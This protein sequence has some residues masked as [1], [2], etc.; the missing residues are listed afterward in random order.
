MFLRKIVLAL[1]AFLVFSIPLAGGQLSFDVS[2]GPVGLMSVVGI[3]A[4]L[5][6]IASLLFGHRG[7]GRTVVP[8]DLSVTMFG[9]FVALNLASVGW[10]ENSSVAISAS[11]AYIQILV[12]VWL[13]LFL[14][15]EP[16]AFS[17]ILYAIFLG[18]FLL[19]AYSIYD[20]LSVGLDSFQSQR[21]G[22]FGVQVNRYALKLALGIPVALYIMYRGLRAFRWLSF[23][24]LPAAA[25]LIFLSGSRTGMAMLIFALLAAMWLVLRVEHR[26]QVRFSVRRL[27]LLAGIVVV[28]SILVGPSL[29]ERFEYH[30][31]RAASL[32]DPLDDTDE[33][34][35]FGGRLHL[36]EAALRAYLDNPIL[37]VGSGGSNEAMLDYIGHE[38]LVVSLAISGRSVHSV[39]VAIASETGTVGVLLWLA[40]LVSLVLRIRTFPRQERILFLSFMGVAL[41]SGIAGTIEA[42]RD[43]NLALFLSVIFSHPQEQPETATPAIEPARLAENGRAPTG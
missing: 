21:F 27:S 2:I 42:A 30:A 28:A 6:A 41:L 32:A 34:S 37:G 33:S 13:L 31:E 10:A 19:V 17:I 36:W 15:S 7:L 25:F 8:M 26:G 20:I 1:M 24:Y 18:S 16:K 38:G 3:L 23:A 11:I 22:G 39:Y 5:F 40:V 14:R 35:G 12:F 9:I 43:F 4:F 29:Y